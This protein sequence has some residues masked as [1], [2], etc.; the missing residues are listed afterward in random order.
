MVE[1]A[2]NVRKSVIKIVDNSCNFYGTGFFIEQDHCVTCHHCICCLE[3]IFIEKDGKKYPAEWRE[4]YSVISSDFS[5]LRV[6]NTGM[7]A[8]ECAA[9]LTPKVEV[10]ILGFTSAT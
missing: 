2:E 9:E 8:L 1:L 3:E 6:T 5:I 10:L 7:N 4:D